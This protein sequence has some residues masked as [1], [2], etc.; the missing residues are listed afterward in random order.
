MPYRADPPPRY[1]PRSA[2]PASCARLL[3]SIHPILARFGGNPALARC[4]ARGAHM[5]RKRPILRAGRLITALL[6]LLATPLGAQEPV[7]PSPEPAAGRPVG[8]V[9]RIPVTGV[10]ELGLA[11]FISRSLAEAEEAG[12][13]AA[14]L[15]IDTPGGRVDAAE[16][17]A[18]AL[19]D[20]GIPVY[21]YVNRRALSAGALIALATDRIYMRPGS[22]IGAA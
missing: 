22:T 3:P 9:Y 2:E 12:A 20:A 13:S 6:A 4:A 15:D 19:E 14:V 5:T 11:P 7:A 10:V 8:S 16:Q 17:I 18:D 1:S 21:A